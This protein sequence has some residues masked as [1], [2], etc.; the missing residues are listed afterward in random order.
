MRKLWHITTICI[1]IGMLWGPLVAQAQKQSKLPDIIRIWTYGTGSTGY[2]SAMGIAGTATNILGVDVRSMGAPTDITRYDALRKGMGEFVLISSISYWLAS[3]GYL[4]YADPA[5][6]GPQRLRLVYGG[7]NFHMGVMTH[8]DS[9]IKTMSD[10]KGK[11]FPYAPGNPVGNRFNLAFLR[12]GN[13]TWDDVKK[14]NFASWSDCMRSVVKGDC[15]AAGTTLTTAAARET[16]ASPR[17]IYVIPMPF[18]DKEGWKRVRDECPVIQQHYATRGAGASPQKPVPNVSYKQPFACYDKLSD[19]VAYAFVKA[20]WEGYEDFKGKTADLIDWD[21]NCTLGKGH[22]E[23]YSIPLHEGAIR[24]FKEK[25]LWTERTE[26]WQQERLMIESKVHTLWAIAPE[27]AK[28]E[29]IS[30]GQ[31][32]WDEWWE[33]YCRSELAKLELK[34]AYP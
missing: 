11:R 12:F 32:G 18:E 27:I 26:K 31:K 4:D 30:V 8:A 19:D 13:L 25:G 16:A 15:D 21:H 29:G 6:W 10:L 23:Q 2:Y 3:R 5:N 24:F 22:L 1:A 9:G 7:Q 34:Y 28:R 14:I 20:L 33:K 17:G